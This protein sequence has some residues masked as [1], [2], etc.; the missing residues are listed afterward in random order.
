MN[1]LVDQGGMSSHPA[2]ERILARE[3]KHG[4]IAAIT[5]A[6]R[7]HYPLKLKPQHF[8]IMVTQAVAIHVSIKRTS[9]D[10]LILD[11]F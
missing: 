2:G 6:F 7:D 9:V 3:H 8:W 11:R 5:A 4:F 10:N 1:K